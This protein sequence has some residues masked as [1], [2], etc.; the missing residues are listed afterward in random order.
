M[1]SRD[2]LLGR[3]TDFSNYLVHL[4]REYSGVEARKNL[5]S[6]L[7][8]RTIEARNGYCLFK[9]AITE[10]P[11]DQMKLFGTVC[12]T[13]TPLSDLNYVTQTME[14]RSTELSQYGLMFS[15]KVIIEAGGNPVFYLDTRSSEGKER[16]QAMWDCFRS[17]EKVGFKS[18][19]FSSFLP[20]INKVDHRN[21]FTSKREWRIVGDF[22]FK[23]SEVF[24]GLCPKDVSI[25]LMTTTLRFRG[26]PLGGAMIK[27]SPNFGSNQLVVPKHE[28][29]TARL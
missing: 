11:P 26:F 12:F 1:P 22:R 25:S 19:P 14:G 23:R 7:K 3:R 5:I 4:T 2:Y 10:L 8:T 20:F 21:D 18:H 17:A 24:L 29:L 6:I 28:A 9:S 13:E 27:S 16:C 15:K